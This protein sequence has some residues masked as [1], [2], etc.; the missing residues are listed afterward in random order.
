MEMEKVTAGGSRD[1]TTLEIER[2]R[3]SAAKYNMQR[4]RVRTLQVIAACCVLVAI[5]TVVLVI[6]GVAYIGGPLVADVFL[7]I[8]M[9][10]AIKK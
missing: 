8:I 1:V 3:A 7:A 5:P 6:A 4:A 9:F 10:E 2:Q